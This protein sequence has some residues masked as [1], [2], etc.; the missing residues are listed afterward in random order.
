MSTNAD[1]TADA[2]CRMTTRRRALEFSLAILSATAAMLVALFPVPFADALLAMY[3]A[4]D[5]NVPPGTAALLAFYRHASDHPHV[6][7]AIAALAGGAAVAVYAV[8]KRN[9]SAVMACAVVGCIVLAMAILLLYVLALM[10]ILYSMPCPLG[11]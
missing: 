5:F 2:T 8:V 3:R 11:T 9:V 10:P 7:T 6:M 4:Y 1:L